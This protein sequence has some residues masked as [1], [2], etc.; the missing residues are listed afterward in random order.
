[1]IKDEDLLKYHDAARKIEADGAEAYQ[2]VSR[3]YGIEVANLLLV[4]HLR[5]GYNPSGQ[6][7]S[8]PDVVEK[9][10]ACLE[11]I[12]LLKKTVCGRDFEKSWWEN[13]TETERREWLES[14]DAIQPDQGWGKV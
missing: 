5:R 14:I 8:P 6:W 4:A 7:P 10:N 13:A 3:L 1:M 12:G 9:V 11:K 2:T